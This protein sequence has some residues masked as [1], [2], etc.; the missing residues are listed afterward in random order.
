MTSHVWAKSVRS[1]EGAAESA[2][3]SFTGRCIPKWDGWDGAFFAL[4]GSMWKHCVVG[5]V[6]SDFNCDAPCGLFGLFQWE[7]DVER[8]LCAKSRPMQPT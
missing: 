4:G 5:L 8:L 3:S 7:R 6:R 2:G 1:A